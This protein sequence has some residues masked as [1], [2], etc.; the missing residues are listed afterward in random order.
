MFYFGQEH[1]VAHRDAHKIACKDVSRACKECEREEV[2][3]RNT[4]D[5]GF[6]WGNAFGT[7]IGHFWVMHETRDCMRARFD[8]ADA[9][10]DM[11]TRTGV[12][13]QLAHFLAMLGLCR[14]DNMGLRSLVPGIMLRLNK[15]QECYYFIKWFFVG[16][17]D[18]DWGNTDLPFL[19]IKDANV[20]EDVEVFTKNKC[21]DLTQLVS[22]TLL[23]IKLLLDLEALQSSTITVGSK[24]PREV[25]D[26]IR[27]GIPLGP[28]IAK[29]KRLVQSDNHTVVILKLR[30]QIGQLHQLVKERNKHLWDLLLSHERPDSPGYYSHGSIEEAD[31]A[32]TN[33]EDA[34]RQL[35]AAPNQP[36]KLS[37][38]AKQGLIVSHLRSTRTCHT[39]KDL[40]K[41]L[42]SVAS[43]NGI[44]VKEYIQ[45][46]TD[47]GK[48]RVEKIG[49]GN[50]YWCFGGDERKERERQLCQ[51]RK[52]VERVQASCKRA[53]ADLGVRRKVLDRDKGDG[54]DGETEELMERKKALDQ[55][56]KRLQNEWTAVSTTGEGKGVG[57]MREEAGEYRQRAQE[58]TDNIYVLEEYVRQLASGDREVVQAVQRECYGEEYVEGEGLRE[59]VWSS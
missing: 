12:E 57:V 3:I 39:L 43:I 4:P 15:D 6:S 56:V 5:D 38:T 11:G 35:P 23:K 37:K 8:W 55:E 34:W 47:D 14:S 21:A 50:W 13:E 28:V 44:Q 2:K 40:E 59:L 49:S 45:E 27:S 29:D 46:L 33:V 10:P 58:W 52:D 26:N 48:I 17:D 24:V 30:Q 9:L 51:L 32:L 20:F 53:K 16:E 18:Y 19:D 1:Q 54:E 42:P 7:G 41:M 31:M 22:L 25:L 36:P